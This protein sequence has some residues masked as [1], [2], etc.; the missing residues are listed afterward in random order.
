MKVA[1]I[2]LGADGDVLRTLP[3]AK[4]IKER[5][6]AE[7]TWVTKGDVAELLEDLPYVSKVERIPFKTNE[8]FDILYN[9]D[10]D[11]QATALAESISAKEKKGFY[12]KGE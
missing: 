11:E 5:Y 8:K 10:I 1:I 3:L 7:I 2:K 6:N 9:F 4:A 12:K